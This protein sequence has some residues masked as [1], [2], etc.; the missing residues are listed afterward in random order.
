MLDVNWARPDRVKSSGAAQTLDMLALDVIRE[1][2][3]E[4]K[5]EAVKYIR[6]RVPAESKYQKDIMQEIKNRAA[7]EHLPCVIWKAAQG[8]YSRSGVSDII[9]LIG[10]VMLAVEVKRPLF[11]EASEL[12]RGF[13]RDV[14]LAGGVAGFCTYTEDIDPLWELLLGKVRR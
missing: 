7:K 8:P 4:S 2:Y 9:A 14:N 3:A 12:Q 11:G 10:G 6:Q 5:A 13:V 1:G